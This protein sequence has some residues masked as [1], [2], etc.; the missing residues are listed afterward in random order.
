MTSR[1]VWKFTHG[2]CLSVDPTKPLSTQSDYFN[3]LD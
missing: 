3:I 1:D 2:V